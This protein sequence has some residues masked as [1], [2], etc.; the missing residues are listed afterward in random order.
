[1]SGIQLALKQVEIGQS[2]PS[3][4][5]QRHPLSN[6]TFHHHHEAREA[7]HLAHDLNWVPGGGGD[8]Q[9]PFP[10]QHCACLFK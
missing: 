3:H 7:L 2:R 4:G 9:S 6:G 5:E 1:M 10:F 8:Q